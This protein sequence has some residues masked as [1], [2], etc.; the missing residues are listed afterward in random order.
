VD[1]VCVRRGRAVFVIADV[2]VG[3][4]KEGVKI[5]CNVNAAAVWI[6]FGGATCSTGVLQARIANKR[7]NPARDLRFK[8]MKSSHIL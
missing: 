1:N 4:A 2:D 7:L 5:T 8:T 3:E 6:S